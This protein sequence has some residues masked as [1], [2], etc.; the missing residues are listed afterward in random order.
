MA[1]RDKQLVV[2]R[3]S[4]SVGKAGD[5]KQGLARMASE[6]SAREVAVGGTTISI[7]DK[8]FSFRGQ[9][10]DDP[11]RVVIL[12]YA[13]INAFYDAIYDPEHP[14]APACF[15]V[16]KIE[17]ELAP[18]EQAPKPQCETVCKDCPHDEFGTDQRGKGKACKNTRKLAVLV[19]T[20]DELD[21]KTVEAA[22][23]AYIN[24]PPASLKNFRGYVKKLTDGLSLPTFAAITEISFDEDMDHEVLM[25]QFAD[26]LPGDRNLLN[27]LVAKR[28]EVEGTLMGTP[29]D[30]AQYNEPRQRGG[31]GD[32]PSRGAQRTSL[33]ATGKKKKF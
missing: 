8:Q 20:G 13:F 11:L 6:D 30:P 33:A 31:K 16:A 19:L 21:A 1:K 26:E 5:W 10:L 7:K 17:A 27:A 4:K 9:A 18:H 15:A 22:E 2:Q 23:V 14:T 25:F 12:D 3:G 29:Y 32:K 24:V 28:Q